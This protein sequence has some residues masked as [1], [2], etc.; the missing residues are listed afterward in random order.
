MQVSLPEIKDIKLYPY[1]E[2]IDA[3]IGEDCKILSFTF[4]NPDDKS[5]QKLKENGVLLIGTCTSVEEAL[6]L[7]KSGIDMICVQGIEAGGHRGSFE[8]ENIPQ[9]GGLSL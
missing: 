1:H 2:Q 3:V 4:G 5:I 9:I 7:E 8:T 6:V